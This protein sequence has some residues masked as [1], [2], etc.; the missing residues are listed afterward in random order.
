MR[1][2]APSRTGVCVAR[3]ASLLT[4]LALVIAPSCGPLCAAQAC[5]PAPGSAGMESHCHLHGTLNGRAPLLHT[6]QN[7][8]APELQAA[9]LTSANW[10]EPAQKDRA[11]A[12]AGRL[13]FLS[14]GL[15]SAG[16]RNSD[17][18]AAEVESPP[19]SCSAITKVV[20]R[21]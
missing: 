21:I 13:A 19:H 3:I 16:A 6:V 15:S 4:I 14:L 5:T 20:L 1:S 17:A 10:R 2:V 8:G 18:I 7:C 9:D 12:S 11:T